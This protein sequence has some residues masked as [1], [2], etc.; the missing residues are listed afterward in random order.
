[1]RYMDY[2]NKNTGIQQGIT[3]SCLGFNTHIQMLEK[4]MLY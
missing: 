2:N 3:N 4:D 1:M